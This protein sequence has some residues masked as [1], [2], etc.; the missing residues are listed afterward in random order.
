MTDKVIRDFVDMVAPTAIMN[1]D[2]NSWALLRTVV[3]APY[4]QQGMLGLKPIADMVHEAAVAM[5]AAIDE[6]LAKEE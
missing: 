3:C 4:L 1:S 6:E 2:S 5:Q